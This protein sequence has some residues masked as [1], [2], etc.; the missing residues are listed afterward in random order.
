MGKRGFTLGELIMVSGI[1][2]AMLGVLGISMMMSR[3][4][5]MTTDTELYVQ[6]EGRKALDN[7]ATELRVG[8]NVNNNVSIG[9]PGVQRLDFQLD[10]GYNLAPPCPANAVCWGT[11][12]PA[13]PTGWAHYVVDPVT[14]AP[15]GRLRRCMTANRL[16]PMPVN[17]AGCR[18]MANNVNPALAMTTF[19][20]DHP[21]RAITATLQVSVTSRQVSGGTLTTG[22]L[23][24]R[25]QIRLRN[26]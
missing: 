14:A 20:Y 15:N 4:A 13:F 18:V 2:V 24:L 25:V 17:F 10:R 8:G 12:D 22:A 23:P 19:L 9:S 6:Q 5:Y 16:D 7:M 1:F 26:P 11:D 3:L 21:T